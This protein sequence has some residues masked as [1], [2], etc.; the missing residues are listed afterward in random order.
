MLK[1]FCT[2]VELKYEIIIF[3]SMITQYHFDE[4]MW[5]YHTIRQQAKLAQI[6]LIKYILKLSYWK[7]TK[8]NQANMLTNSVKTD[9]GK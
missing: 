7:L 1:H 2:K 9:E 5:Q 3:I 4:V 6:C 8:K